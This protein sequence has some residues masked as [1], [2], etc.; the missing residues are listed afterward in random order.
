MHFI[1][2]NQNNEILANAISKRSK[3][4]LKL[5]SKINNNSSLLVSS[6][7]D[8]VKKYQETE[9]YLH[10]TL[11]CYSGI[12]PSKDTSINPQMILVFNS[13]R[14]ILEM[15]GFPVLMREIAEIFECGN[16]LKYRCID[17]I[18]N[19]QRYS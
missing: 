1:N 14:R 17:F 19:L 6:T 18:S 15:P 3:E 11:E 2:T 12:T 8:K 10:E 13:R 9:K 5:G 16:I 4:I 7:E